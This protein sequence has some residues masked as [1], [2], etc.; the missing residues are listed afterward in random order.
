MD[1]YSLEAVTRT[2][3]QINGNSNLSVTAVA[4]TSTTTSSTYLPRIENPY[5][6]YPNGDSRNRRSAYIIPIAIKYNRGNRREGPDIRRTSRR[7]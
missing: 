1:R 3:A 4:S 6:A 2:L 5:A 7:G